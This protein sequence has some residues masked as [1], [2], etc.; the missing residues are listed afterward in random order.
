MI[1]IILENCV[2]NMKIISLLADLLLIIDINFF[3]SKESSSM[4]EEKIMKYIK[5]QK[6]LYTVIQLSTN[7]EKLTEKKCLLLIEA[8]VPLHNLYLL[9]VHLFCRSLISRK[10]TKSVILEL[11][12]LATKNNFFR[13]IISDIVEVLHNSGIGLTD[14]LESYNNLN[15]G[16]VPTQIQ[17]VNRRW[18]VQQNL[19][20]VATTIE[21]SQYIQVRYCQI[22]KK[23]ELCTE[24]EKMVQFDNPLFHSSSE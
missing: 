16:V 10:Y 20:R 7:Q 21:I 9:L 24:N 4:L 14:V 13:C 17:E 12:E 11:D 6:E 8:E 15:C 23:L 1:E 18:T 3:N 19:K 22:E 5:K 2:H